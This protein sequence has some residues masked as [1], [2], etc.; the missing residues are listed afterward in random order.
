MIY[1]IIIMAILAYFTKVTTKSSGYYETK[2][3]KDIK[4]E[5]KKGKE[6]QKEAFKRLREADMESRQQNNIGE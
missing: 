1:F 3:F 4:E 6:L 2:T 5:Y